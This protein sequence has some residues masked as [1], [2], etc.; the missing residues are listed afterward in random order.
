MRMP[1]D[2]NGTWIAHAEAHVL[3]YEVEVLVDRPPILRC[4][5]VRCKV[6]CEMRFSCVLC[7]LLGPFIHL[8]ICSFIHSS[9]AHSFVA[10]S[11][12]LGRNVQAPER[13]QQ[14]LS[15]F[16]AGVLLEG[17]NVLR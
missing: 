15:A 10:S 1:S 11:M 3:R 12:H 6:W 13:V 17:W 4:I 5:L 9:S 14:L 8:F 7:D 2:S 16:G